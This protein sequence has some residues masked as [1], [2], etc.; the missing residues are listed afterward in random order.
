MRTGWHDFNASRSARGLNHPNIAAIFGLENNR[1][2]RTG[3]GLVEVR[4]SQRIAE[5][6]PL[7]R[8]CHREADRGRARAAHEQESFMRSQA[9]NIKVREDGTVVLDLVREGLEHSGGGK[10]AT[11]S[12]TITAAMMTGLGVILGRR[13]T[14]PEQACGK[15]SI[16]GRCVSLRLRAFEM[17]TGRRVFDGRRSPKR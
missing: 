7:M 9:A 15:R 17:L 2:H 1:L 10:R 3:H 6:D 8:H 4:I 11:Q 13:R 14:G 5:C 16:N 12:P